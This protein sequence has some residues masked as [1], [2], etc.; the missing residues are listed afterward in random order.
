MERESDE[1]RR[2]EIHAHRSILYGRRPPVAMAGAAMADAPPVAIDRA[3]NRRSWGS[4]RDAR[5]RTSA[6]RADPSGQC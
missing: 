3:A 4:G 1:D 2:K 5:R 6:R